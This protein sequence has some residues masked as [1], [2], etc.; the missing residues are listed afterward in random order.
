MGVIQSQVQSFALALFEL[1]EVSA[2][3]FLQPVKVTLNRNPALQHI[4]LPSVR[5]HP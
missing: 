1:H 5:Y 2:T 3:S 4:P